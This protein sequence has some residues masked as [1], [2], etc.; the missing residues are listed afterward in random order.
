MTNGNSQSNNS[1]RPYNLIKG[2]PS[3]IVYA[4]L[5][6]VAATLSITAGFLSPATIGTVPTGQLVAGAVFIAELIK[7][8]FA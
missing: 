3:A 8:A 7:E 1:L 2:I 6:L 5:A 4:L